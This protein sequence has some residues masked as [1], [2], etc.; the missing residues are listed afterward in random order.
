MA[1]TFKETLKD[2]ATDKKGLK[3]LHDM[4][5]EA[6]EEYEEKVIESSRLA[7][8]IKEE[9]LEIRK[10]QNKIT[11]DREEVEVEK[12]NFHELMAE[13]GEKDKETKEGLSLLNARKG[14]FHDY[15]V[16]KKKELKTKEAELKKEAAEVRKA[17]KD[18]EKEA[19]DLVKRIKRHKE[20]K[21]D[22][23]KKV[24]KLETAIREIL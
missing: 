13:L 22:F 8:K 10:I 16:A 19:A 12:N 2:V 23:D 6:I 7:S 11:K 9:K 15:M 21:D 24:S 3:K 1:K 5:T 20:N 17:S 4:V 18:L 14:N